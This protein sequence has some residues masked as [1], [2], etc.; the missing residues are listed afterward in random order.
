[1]R[2]SLRFKVALFFSV[3]TIAL[4]VAQSLGVRA[5]AEAQEER[6]IAALIRDDMTHVLKGYQANPALLPPFD[7]RMNG[8]VSGAD[9]GSVALPGTVR[10]LPFG[11][12]EIIIDEREIHVVIALWARRACT[13]CTTSIS[14][15]SISRKSSMR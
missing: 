7:V 10:S 12:L 14:T 15:K 1:M 13:A 2:N 5:L 6:L 9:R 4:L 3:L 8:Y 11:T